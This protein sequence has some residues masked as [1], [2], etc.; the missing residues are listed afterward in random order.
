MTDADRIGWVDMAKALSII[1]VVMMYAAYNVGEH[2]GGIGFLHYV[3][4][5][6]TPF[7]MPEFFLISGLFLSHVIARPWLRYA[8]RRVLHY[9]YFYALWAAIMIALKVGLY[10]GAPLDAVNDL[11]VAVVHPYGVLWFV[12]MLAVFGL[13]AKLLWQVKAPHW[14]VLILAAALQMV[15]LDFGVFAATQFAA[16]FLFFYIGYA[17]APFVFALVAAAERQVAVASAALVAWALV[18]GLL[19]FSDGF[20]VTAIGMKMGGW[21]SFAPIHLALAI[22]GTL[23]LCIASVLLSKLPGLGWLRWLGEHSLVVYLAFTIPMS[24][25]R[26]LAVWSGLLTEPGP[27]SA[28]VLMVSIVCPV[29][30]YLVIRR[31][32][33]GLFLFERPRWA[34]LPDARPS[35]PAVATGSL[36]PFSSPRASANGPYG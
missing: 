18:N 27:L 35:R 29:I 12:Y 25:F 14:A 33:I 36:A 4:G 31:L 24:I 26:G 7:R 22:S 19:V 1:L 5:F 17:G 10:G 30:L 28:A 23:A 3:I 20:A 21:A 16:Y 32:G 6:A 34:R 15:Q 13:A 9:V 8:D 11:R 2:T